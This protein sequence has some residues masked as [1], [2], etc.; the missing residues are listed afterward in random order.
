MKQKKKTLKRN[1]SIISDAEPR[2]V[3]I[4]NHGANQT[5]FTLVKSLKLGEKTMKK[6]K[7]VR[8]VRKGQL[9]SGVQKLTF[10]VENFPSEVEVRKYLDENN[11]DAESY[12]IKKEKN[13]FVVADVNLTEDN[14]TNVRKVATND[15]GV[16]GYVG[17]IIK[18]SLADDVEVEEISDSDNEEEVVEKSAD[19]VEPILIS[20]YDFWA[21]YMSNEN[22]LE[23][24][25]KD[26]MRDGVP[27]GMEDILSGMYVAISNTLTSDS[28]DRKGM[29]KQIGGEMADLVFALHE[30]FEGLKGSDDD[31]AKKFVK[32]HSEFLQKYQPESEKSD[33]DKVLEALNAI[34]KR[35]DTIENTKDNLEEVSELK[36]TVELLSKK[37]P[38]RKSAD[39][40]VSDVDDPVAL[41]KQKEKQATDE[42]ARKAYMN[43]VGIFPDS[44]M[45]H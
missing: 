17:E 3:S 14:F 19:T 36:K 10:S 11:W 24:V 42:I 4:V 41:H 23:G 22:S 5:P 43:A 28:E 33:L 12:T 9:L 37:A 16:E 39:V 26:G 18:E 8:L 7:T 34:N 40:D 15:A 38:V 2:Y 25:M 13:L 27:P 32:S 45:R 21:A 6:A 30:V 44:T 35:I 29:L 31:N 1:I 20:K